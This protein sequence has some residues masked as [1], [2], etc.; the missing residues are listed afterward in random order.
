MSKHKKMIYIY[1]QGRPATQ[2][3]VKGLNRRKL[4]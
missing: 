3:K 4:S 2:V 1:L